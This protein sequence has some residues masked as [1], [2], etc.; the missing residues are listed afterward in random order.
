MTIDYT[1]PPP[2]PEPRPAGSW[3]SRN[4]KWV[5]PLGCLTPLLL[6]GSCV[7]GIVFFVFTA[8]K[9][10]D[11]YTDAVQRAQTDPRVVTALGGPVEAGWW[12]T[13]NIDVDGSGGT[14]DFDV[15][16]QG[17]AKKGTLEIEA[18]RDSGGWNYSV[19]RVHVDDG[20]TI[21]LIEPDALS[22]EESDYTDPAGG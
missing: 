22:P 14:A 15:P 21:D 1:Q 17:T 10:S 2:S 8:I 16:L 5:V 9:G 18:E 4:W 11:A 13:G 19:M 7:A 6:I 3:W 12:V 20:T